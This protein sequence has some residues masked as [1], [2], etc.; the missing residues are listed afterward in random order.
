MENH[1]RP[2]PPAG[3]TP[4]DPPAPSSSTR[5]QPRARTSRALPTDRM[6]FDTQ[7]G[8]LL[9]IA[10][11]SSNGNRSVGSVDIATRIGV[12]PATAGL[13]N[14]FFME[15]GLIKREKKGRYKPTQAVLEFAR[16]HSFDPKA[17]GKLLAE[18]LSRSWAFREVQQQRGM[19]S[20]TER[21]MVEVLAA[22][23]GATAEHRQQL[24][25]ILAW[26]QYAGLI[27]LEGGLVKLTPEGAA[28]AAAGAEP[29]PEPKPGGAGDDPGHDE[30]TDPASTGTTT[31]LKGR[32]AQPEPI[33]G[34]SFEFALTADD[35]PKLSPEQIKA[36]FEAV[37]SV[38]AIKATI[39]T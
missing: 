39:K 3:D 29:E 23:A 28:E 10:V 27:A 33:M 7:V 37:G 32:E 6:K 31:K 25:T 36:L 24:L 18:P 15:C 38:M 12:S 4:A 17:A 35:L 16:Q 8:A 2:V 19:G 22:A 34:F 20:V 1:L 14:A 26:L 9:A 30:E 11:S 5:S 21:R 13:S